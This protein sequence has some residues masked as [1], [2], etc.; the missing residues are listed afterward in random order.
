[1]YL[2]VKQLVILSFVLSKLVKINL[3]QFLLQSKTFILIVNWRIWCYLYLPFN[4]SSFEELIVVKLENPPSTSITNIVLYCSA[5][6][7]CFF[8]IQEERE[9]PILLPAKDTLF[10]PFL[11]LE[12]LCRLMHLLVIEP[13][14]SD[15][16][17]YYFRIMRMWVKHKAAC[18]AMQHALNHISARLWEGWVHMV[19]LTSLKDREVGGMGIHKGGFLRIEGKHNWA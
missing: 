17:V 6:W 1:M 4:G 10:C 15:V 14:L 5:K 12:I 8:N 3:V 16:N 2:C 19:N 18:E 7:P 11:N 9:S 13:Y